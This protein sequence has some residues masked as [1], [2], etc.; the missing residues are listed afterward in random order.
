MGENPWLNFKWDPQPNLDL[1]AANKLLIDVYPTSQTE[2]EWSE[3]LVLKLAGVSQDSSG[4]D[5]R[6]SIYEKQI[7]RLTANEWNTVEIDLTSI[8]ESKEQVEQI[9]FYM[10]TGFTQIEGRSVITYRLDNLRITQDSEGVEVE[11]VT[12]NVP[13]GV[14]LAGAQ[15]QLASATANASIYYTADGSD[16]RT[17]DARLLYSQPIVINQT[18]QIQAY[19]TAA[20]YM[21][22]PVSAWDYEIGTGVLGETLYNWQ[23]FINASGSI[24]YAPVFAANSITLDGSLDDWDGYAD[25]ALPADPSRQ[26]FLTGWGGNNDLSAHV[27]YAYD[28][29]ALYLGIAVKDNIHEAVAGDAMWTGDG[30]QIA[31][32]S[33]GSAYGP[34]YGFADVGGTPQV[35][36]WNAGAAVLGKDAVQLVTLQD[37]DVTTYEAK[38]PWQAISAQAGPPTAGKIPFAFLI[39][40]NDGSGR[41]GWVQWTGGIGSVK[42]PKQFATLGLIPQDDEWGVRLEGETVLNSGQTA[43]Y[44]VYVPNYSDHDIEVHLTSSVF[45]LDRTVTIPAGMMLRKRVEMTVTETGTRALTISGEDTTTSQTRQDSIS[46]RIYYSPSE[47]NAQ[48]EQLADRMPALEQLFADA[49]AQRIPTDYERVNETVLRNFIPYGKDDVAH[50]L[51]E[52]AEY[53]ASELE[54]L[55]DEAYTRLQG[56]LNGTLEAWNVPRY[57][58]GTT[59]PDISNYS[60][61]ADTYDYAS[62]TTK[63]GTVFF[64]GYGHFGQVQRDVPQFQDY[65][66]NVIQM[67]IGPDSVIKSPDAPPEWEINRNGGV[68]AEARA[69]LTVKRSGGASLVITNNSPMT[70]NVGLTLYQEVDVMPNTSYTL[71]VWV[72]GDN[73]NDAWFPGGKGWAYRTAIP[74]GTYDWQ[75]VSYVYTTGADETSFGFRIGSDSVTGHLWVDDISMTETVDGP[76]LIANPGFDMSL[77]NDKDYLITDRAIRTEVIPVLQNASEHNVAVN[78]LLS[79]HYFPAWALEEWPE[80]QSNNNGFIRF[81]IDAPKAKAIIEDYLRTI[82]PLIKDYPSLQSVVLSN[83]SVYQSAADPQNLPRW[84]AYLSQLYNGDIDE[85]NQIYGT[86]YTSFEDVGMPAAL[87]RTPFYYDWVIFNNELFS[88][89]HE[90]MADIIHEIAP[91]LPVNVKIM[92]GDLSGDYSL[93]WGVDPEQFANLSQINGNDNWGLLES[94]VKGRLNELRFYDLQSSLKEAPIYNSEQHIFGDRDTNYVPQ[95]AEHARSSIWQGAIHGVSASTIWVWERTYDTGS[96]FWGSILQRP[97]AVAAVGKTSLDLNRLAAKVTAFQEDQPK[98]AILRSTPSTVYNTQYVNAL[99][100]A[101]EAVSFSGQRVGFVTEP[102]IIA[103]KLNDFDL[104]IVPQAT[105]V[106]AET[107]QQIENFSKGNETN[108][109]IMGNGSLQYDE[110]NTPLSTEVRSE[111]FNKALTLNNITS[112]EQL[113]NLLLPLFTALEL[114]RVM[115]IDTATNQPAYD[116]EWRSVN[117]DGKWLINIDNYGTSPKTVKLIIDGQPV[118]SSKELI[119]GTDMNAAQLVLSPLQPYLLSV[120]SSGGDDGDGESGGGGGSGGSGGSGESGGGGRSGDSIGNGTS[121]ATNDVVVQVNGK[122]IVNLPGDRLE[123]QILLADVGDLPLTVNWSNFAV[124]IDRNFLDALKKLVEDIQGAQL[125]IIKK[126]LS[127]SIVADVPAAGGAARIKLAG[128]PVDVSIVLIAKDGKVIN[129]EQIAGGVTLTFHYE[130]GSDADLLGIYY[131]N[132]NTREWEYI[133]GNTDKDQ[134]TITVALQH[135][136][137]YAVLSYEKSFTDVPDAHWASRAIRVLAAKH[138]VKGMTDSQ[139]DLAGKTTRAQFTALLVRLLDLKAADGLTPFA[140]VDRDA[141]YAKEIAAAYAAGLVNGKTARSFAPNETISREQMAVMLVRAYASKY[142]NPDHLVGNALTFADGEQI[143]DWAKADVSQAAVLGLLSGKSNH[144]FDPKSGATR[145]ESAQAIFNWLIKRS[146][147]Q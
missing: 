104:L 64:T 33:D 49:E 25:V 143:A 134:Q 90:W 35:W 36:R 68:Q 31:F 41:R 60:F 59:R 97:D 141:W 16:P 103:G 55:Y 88:G 112:A 127:G 109:V 133:G 34:E 72:K 74:N 122:V 92:N 119:G 50:G 45:D 137:T 106:K 21:D 8:A 105:H 17:S 7:P 123:A 96:D 131:L 26:V 110:H 99:S 136:S 37:G 84:H 100:Q 138:M 3:P 125:K 91:D 78:L 135:L 47:L 18:M 40:D 24:K 19:A 93:T 51:L 118:D 29:D 116:V 43:A 107:L 38:I 42:D 20:S 66:A 6:Y 23:A 15:V 73:V 146:I 57:V 2:E 139:F 10:Y 71:K 27:H 28:Q 101:Y 98:V 126:P 44:S 53:V 95:Q 86:S 117:V 124:D 113:R 52:R 54:S 79:P 81:N 82:I 102:Q 83:E 145:A 85:L 147:S 39:N 75:E 142:G 1:S 14:V 108:V 13:G 121:S 46:V 114:D 128:Q 77:Q 94:G 132:E 48:F 32:S 70:P 120:A 67:E 144:Q 12:A 130:S 5:Q 30:I 115:L 58:T 69:D 63:P 56:Y 22:S 80:L 87:E 4:N 76:N 111:L 62:G 65:G 129:V 61:K 89:W 11:P 140:D 9:N